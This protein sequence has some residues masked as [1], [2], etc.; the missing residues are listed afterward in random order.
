[1]PGQR[2][3]AAN[4]FIELIKQYPSHDLSKSACTELK[5]LGRNCPTASAAPAR[6]NTKKK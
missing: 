5:N 1:M 2:T 4:E 6:K 3:A